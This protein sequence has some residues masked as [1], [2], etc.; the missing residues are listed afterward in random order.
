MSKILDII[1][2]DDALNK[3]MGED[4]RIHL[5]GIQELG[6]EYFKC[7]Y[8]TRHKPKEAND[9][10]IHQ[11]FVIMFVGLAMASKY[12]EL[13]NPTRSRVWGTEIQS[14]FNRVYQA[15]SSGANP[16][17][18]PPLGQAYGLYKDG[19][20]DVQYEALGTNMFD[21]FSNNFIPI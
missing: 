18:T 8:I 14:Q 21:L 13:A 16:I 4:F 6:K 7:K 5:Q 9:N 15:Y 1:N 20:P 19:D 17:S 11:M 12:M 2:L 3:I 10:D